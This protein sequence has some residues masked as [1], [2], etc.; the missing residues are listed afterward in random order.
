M[1]HPY[2]NVYFNKGWA[3]HETMDRRVHRLQKRPDWF[4]R[5]G[6]VLVKQK[7]KTPAVEKQSE[8]LGCKD[9]LDKNKEN[10]L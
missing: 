5:N 8:T 7:G 6:K 10:G 9:N 4:M 1:L 2:I 3:P